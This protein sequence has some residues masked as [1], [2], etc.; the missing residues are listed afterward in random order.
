MKHPRVYVA[1][2]V[3]IL[4]MLACQAVMGRGNS[5]MDDASPTA[6]SMSTQPAEI[7]PTQRA[8]PEST[9]TAAPSNPGVSTDFPM[10]EDAYNVIQSE[11]RSVLYYTK[12]SAEGAMQFYRDEFT[13]KGYTERKN[14]TI[15]G[16]GIFSMVF[17]GDPSG[18]SV[19]IQSVDLGDGS[20][21]VSLRLEDV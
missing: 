9:N 1:I 4:P 16:D 11:D 13:A 6:G 2:V 18:K 15:A 19:V 10:T 17:D 21:T 7:P 8:A 3:L 14:L 20:R 12:L 5:D